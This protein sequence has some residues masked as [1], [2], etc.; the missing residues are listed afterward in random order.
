MRSVVFGLFVLSVIVCIV[1]TRGK[2][3]LIDMYIGLYGD[4]RMSKEFSWRFGLCSKQAVSYLMCTVSHSK[5]RQWEILLLAQL[6]GT[7][8]K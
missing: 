7:I 2:A 8:V 3:I 4:R 6:E 1:C 5:T